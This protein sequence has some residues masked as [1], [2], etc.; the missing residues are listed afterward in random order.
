M[1]LK[2]KIILVTASTRGIGLAIVKLCAKE[3]ATVYMA[4]RNLEQ[5][6]LIAEELN[7]NGYSIKVVYNDANKQETYISMIDEV[8]KNEGKIDVLI[9]NFGTSNPK[10][11]LNIEYTKYDDF[12]NIINMN[13]SSVFI[14]SQHAI[15]Y[16]KKNGGSIINISSISGIVPDI[17]QIAYGVSKASINYL[18][19]EIAGQAASYNIRCNAILP[20][21]TATDAVNNNLTSVF[22][23]Y[24]LRHSPIKR[25]AF[26]EEIANAAIYFASDESAFTTG[27]IL[28]IHGGFGMVTPLYACIN[29]SKPVKKMIWPLKSFYN[30]VYFSYYSFYCSRNL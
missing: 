24:F 5:A 23:D 19:K 4:A 27:Q 2:N 22:K 20:G 21:M 14:A 12:I 10:I 17:S 7:C 25:M 18:T 26:P 16:M 1:R 6:N 11:D 3:G 28:A 13:I 9:N 30:L 8:I 15:K 29:L